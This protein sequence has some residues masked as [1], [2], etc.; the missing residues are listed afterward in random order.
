M[1]FCEGNIYKGQ[2]VLLTEYGGIAFE[3]SSIET[4]GYFGSVKT[5]DEF[6]YRY[7]SVTRAVR[8]V[9]YIKGYCYTQ[10][11][12]V[13][14]EVNGLLTAD[15]KVKVNIEKIRKINS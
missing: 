2:P 13:M 6:F 5:A 12:D 3:S 15:R 4:W 9:D 10:L 8:N 7:E 11:T 14:Q 1:L